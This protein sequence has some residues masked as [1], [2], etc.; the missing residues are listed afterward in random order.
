MPERITEVRWILPRR[1]CSRLSA[2]REGSGGRMTNWYRLVP[3]MAGGRVRRPG[4][5]K[6]WGGGGGGFL[7]AW[8]MV[9]IILEGSLPTSRELGLGGGGGGM[10]WAN[11]F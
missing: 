8:V 5:L 4:V 2:L 11:S 10:P 1:R 6:G 7:E 9:F 3:I